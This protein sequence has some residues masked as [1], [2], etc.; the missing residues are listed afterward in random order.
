M[1]TLI[2]HRGMSHL[3]PENTLSAFSLAKKYNINWIECDVDILQDGTLVVSHDDTLDRCTDRHGKIH[4]LRTEDL[5]H[6][7]AGSWF[8][9]EYINERIPTV[10]NLIKLA[11]NIKLN[12]NIEIKSCTAGAYFAHKLIDGIILSLEELDDDCELI[13]SSFNYLMLH[14]IK[15]LRP[16]TQVACLFETHTLYDDWSSII[17]WCGA[18]YIHPENNG[19]TE[20]MVENFKLANLKINVWTVND[21]NRANQIFNWGVDGIFTDIGHKFPSKYRNVL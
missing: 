20:K 16:K 6:I 8:S 7:D 1:K 9:D 17:E 21:L 3:A 4:T 14:E 13:I 11:N 12:L 5:I 10:A 2:A 19:L 18:E 15:K